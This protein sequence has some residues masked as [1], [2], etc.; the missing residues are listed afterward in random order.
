MNWSAL[1][2]LKWNQ[3]AKRKPPA[4]PL[5]CRRSKAKA[6]KLQLIAGVEQ[7]F[8]AQEAGKTLKPALLAVAEVRYL[9]RS[10]SVDTSRV[11]S[12][13]VEDP[14]ETGQKWE[15]Y[16]SEISEEAIKGSQPAKAKFSDLPEFMQNKSWWSQQEKE[17]EHWIFETDT[18]SVLINKTLGISAGPDMSKV[19]FK[20]EIQKAAQEKADAEIKKLETSFK[21]K[22]KTLKDRVN[23]QEA[24][25]E[26]YQKELA[27]RG[28]DAA[29]KVGSTLLN[30]ASK[31]KLTGVSTS[32]TKARMTSDAKGR[33]DEAKE[34]LEGYQ[35]SLTELQQKFED[36]KQ[37]ALDKWLAAGE[38]FEE[39]KLTPTKQN[40]RITYFGDWLERV[41]IIRC[42]EL[43]SRD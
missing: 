1:L 12:A 9:S 29:L 31:K 24:K 14:R 36:D 38:D 40:I 21:T 3:P 27:S 43:R 39:V 22:E 26:K 18:V 25:V 17:F 13:L 4:Q 6:A 32:M 37:T 35:T 28:L 15:D 23:S 11:I 30:L 42:L 41:N 34:K 8:L 2:R 10:P 33:L 20:A 7:Y 5:L 16:T 19:D